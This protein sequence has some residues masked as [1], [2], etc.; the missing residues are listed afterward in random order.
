MR[1][2]IDIKS[3]DN[4]LFD[5]VRLLLQHGQLA[6]AKAAFAAAQSS[7]SLGN[8]AINQA[9]TN[10]TEAYSAMITVTIISVIFFSDCH[11]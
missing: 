10:L 3:N 6:H 9:N 4:A 2:T 7:F 1:D 11:L 8:P 5:Y